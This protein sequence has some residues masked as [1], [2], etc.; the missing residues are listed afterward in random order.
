[1]FTNCRELLLLN[2]AVQLFCFTL[3]RE[4]NC[5]CI[6]TCLVFG[7]TSPTSFLQADG[8]WSHSVPHCLAPC[9]VPNI[10]K[11]RAANMSTGATVRHG[12]SV[13][14]TCD[15]DFELAASGNASS[16]SGGGSAV[17]CSNGTWATIPR[18]EPARCKVLPEPPQDGMVVVRQCHTRCSLRRIVISPFFLPFLLISL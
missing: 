6:Q 8:K 4:F 16:A 18:C 7:L 5:P 17:T 2:G 10:E 9:I 12:E 13:N 11:G 1:M 15:D 3:S 14:I